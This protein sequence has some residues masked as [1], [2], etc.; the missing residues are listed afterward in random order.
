M[1]EQDGATARRRL[2]EVLQGLL[3]ARP[4]RRVLDAG[5]G[6]DSTWAG[7]PIPPSFGGA[8]IVGIDISEHLVARNTRV[9]EALVGD[10][11]TYPFPEASF[12]VVGCLDVLEHVRDP[13][14]ALL[15]LTRALAPG[16]LLVLAL[17]NVASLKG[18]ITKFTP[19]RFHVWVYKHYWNVDP[20]EGEQGRGPFR[21]Y[22][23][24]SLRRSRL[25]RFARRHG[26]VVEHEVMWGRGP[27]PPRSPLGLSW[28]AVA[29]A[30]RAVTLGRMEPNLSELGLILRKG[31]AGGT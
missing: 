16:G 22:L 2:G 15:N 29:L 7:F 13:T 8:H 14:R 11:A 3:E 24:F 12:D 27:F 1:R 18:L 26:L 19:H 21:T 23:R 10:I 4:P 9:A 20:A 17:P 31:S 6:F 25:H 28:R 5:C 30:M